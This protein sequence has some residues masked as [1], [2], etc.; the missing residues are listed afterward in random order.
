MNQRQDEHRRS[1]WP[2]RLRAGAIL[3][4]CLC[5]G[6]A[7]LHA[8]LLPTGESLPYGPSESGYFVGWRFGWPFFCGSGYST[9][10]ATPSLPRRLDSVYYL[11]VDLFIAALLVVSP[12]VLCHLRRSSR[13]R[14][15]Q[16]SLSNLFMVTTA[17]A[18]L[19]SL[20]AVERTCGWAE[21]GRLGL[22]CS[23]LLAYPWYDQAP[24]ALGVICASYVAIAALCQMFGLTVL[25]FR[26][27]S[28][29]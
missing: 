10:P 1:Q 9:P 18:M 15:S 5:I 17:V 11:M 2:S 28:K 22:V 19:F 26:S 16:F 20:I 13:I 8:N 14:G 6:A 21:S 12:A 25:R 29:D 4:L 7:M 27:A 24:I 23:A 3:L